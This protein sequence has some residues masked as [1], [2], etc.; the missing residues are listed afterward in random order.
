MSI[1]K[2][3]FRCLLSAF[4]IAAFVLPPVVARAADPHGKPPEGSHGFRIWIG[5]KGVWH[6]APHTDHPHTFTGT[7]HV[8]GAKISGATGIE[9]FEK[10]DYWRIDGATNTITF[11]LTT[12]GKSD[13]VNLMLTKRADS[14]TVNVREDGQAK[15]DRVFIGHTGAHPASIP[16][17]VSG[18]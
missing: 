16:F 10:G 12:S 6:F 5:E 2:T 17:T 1:A 14:L 13:R 7:I 4:V 11:K 9:T 3:A 18:R 8:V 15:P